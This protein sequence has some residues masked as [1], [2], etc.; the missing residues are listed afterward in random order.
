MRTLTELIQDIEK[1][2]IQ[3]L[4]QRTIKQYGMYSIDEVIEN[5]TSAIHLD[6]QTIDSFDYQKQQQ[7]NEDKTELAS[8]VINYTM[9]IDPSATNAEVLV[10]INE[11]I[12]LIED[13]LAK[14]Q[15]QG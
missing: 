6:Q 12:D 2:Q 7:P 3:I 13:Q 15:Q 5:P 11:Y 10:K 8:H 4:T 14:K 1:Y 9:L